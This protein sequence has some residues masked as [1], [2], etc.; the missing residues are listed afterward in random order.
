[1]PH[2]VEIKQH[3]C[4]TAN[5]IGYKDSYLDALSYVIVS[6]QPQLPVT[7]L[8]LFVVIHLPLNFMSSRLFCL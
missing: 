1:M 3:P 2:E 8:L 5:Q 7:L 4:A 6:C